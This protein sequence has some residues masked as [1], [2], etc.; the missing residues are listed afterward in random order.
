MESFV[1]AE[2]KKQSSWSKT[3]PSLFH[4]RTVLGREVDWVLEDRS[5]RVVGIEVKASKTI[6]SSDV[7]GMK[8][9]RETA[10]KHFH[11]GVVFY[12]GEEVVPFGQGLHACPLPVL[13]S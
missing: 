8:A 2:L 12:A 5:G 7:Q 4:F 6:T 9:L 13:W 10:G 3:K 11:A 1:A